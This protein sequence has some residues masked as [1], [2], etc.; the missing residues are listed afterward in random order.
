[1][2][3]DGKRGQC[4]PGIL[5]SAVKKICTGS[6][7]YGLCAMVDRLPGSLLLTVLWGNKQQ[8][9]RFHTQGLGLFLCEYLSKHSAGIQPHS[10]LGVHFI[11]SVYFYHMLIRSASLCERSCVAEHRA[12]FTCFCRTQECIHLLVGDLLAIQITESKHVVPEPALIQLSNWLQVRGALKCHSAFPTGCSTTAH[13]VE[14]D[15]KPLSQ[16]NLSDISLKECDGLMH[17]AP[18]YVVSILVPTCN[19]C[20]MHQLVPQI[21]NVSVCFISTHRLLWRL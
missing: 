18:V 14:K 15:F 9:N 5:S 16:W 11:F 6:I 13:N 4:D 17:T 7:I 21:K 12:G 10:L 2:N 20:T 19:L 3:I 8:W 1:M